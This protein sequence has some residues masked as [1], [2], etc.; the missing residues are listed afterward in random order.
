MELS[1]KSFSGPLPPLSPGETELA[2][3]LRHHVDALAGEIGA[4]SMLVYDNFLRAQNYIAD[5]W[6]EAGFSVQREEFLVDLG[7]SQFT[8]ANLIVEIR[9]S[10]KPDEIL[11]LG[12]HYDTVGETCPGANDNASGV[13]ALIELARRS[14]MTQPARTLRFVAF[15]NEE[16]PFFMTQAMGSIVH[17]RA[18][19]KRGEKIIGM[20][21]LETIGYY[22]SAPGSQAYPAPLSMNYPKTGDFIAFVANLASAPLL[23][24]TLE[25]FRKH[26][27]FPSQGLA[28]PGS[29]P[30]IDWSD[31]AAFW[32]EG[33]PALMVTDTAVFRYPYYHED[34]D[35]AEKLDYGALARV[36]GGLGETL[37][38]LSS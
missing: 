15:A 14:N 25:A 30:G 23:C 6:R 27:Q 29:M 16:P 35:T 31:H 3:I 2:Y 32:Q 9:G 18:A 33:Y 26:T 5:C 11:L 19:R 22:S 4:R 37:L 12:A 7:L 36:T 13:A 8:A 34:S 17:A 10:S 28:A 21:S 1:G 38:V 20:F 24:R